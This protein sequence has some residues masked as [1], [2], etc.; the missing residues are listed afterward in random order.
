MKREPRC[1]RWRR[2]LLELGPGVGDGLTPTVMAV[3]LALQSHMDNDSGVCWPSQKTLARE[4]RTSIASA[5]RAIKTLSELG[6]IASYSPEGRRTKEYRATVPLEIRW[7][8]NCQ[9]L[10]RATI[11]KG[12]RLLSRQAS[13]GR[14]SRRDVISAQPNSPTN[15]K[16]NWVDPSAATPPHARPG[17]RLSEAE[18]L[19]QL[20]SDAERQGIAEA[21]KQEFDPSQ[22]PSAFDVL[23]VA[24]D[25]PAPI[26]KLAGKYGV[27]TE[28]SDGLEEAPDTP[29][30]SA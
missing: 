30:A 13:Y 6:W 24:A 25:N 29:R 1:L 18:C 20:L 16:K 2:L 17:I 27:K 19:A 4:A 28:K 15:S 3:A 14:A 9:V 23:R 10:D 5:N 26:L 7:M 21:L 8:L 22:H 12:R 11:E